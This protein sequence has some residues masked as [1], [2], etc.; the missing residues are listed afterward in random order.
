MRRRPIRLKYGNT[1]AVT[2]ASGLL[3]SSFVLAAASKWN[4]IGYYHGHV[5]KPPG[6]DCVPI[7][8]NNLETI[9]PALNASRPDLIIHLAA[10]TKPDWCEDHQRETERLNVLAT[11]RLA[12]WAAERKVR[13]VFL[14]TDS[15]FD[16]KKGEYVERDVPRPLNVYATTKLQAEMIVRSATADHLIVRANMY[17]WNAQEK[18]SLAEWILERLL[19]AQQV[20]GFVDV[21]FSPLLVNTLADVILELIERQASGTYHVASADSISKYDFASSLASLF[22]LDASLCVKVFSK[23]VPF[24]AQRPLNTSMRPLALERDYGIEA[25]TVMTD[26]ERFKELRD[27]GFA[28]NL[29]HYCRFSL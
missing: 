19:R 24:R 22:G 4:V 13:I 26:L 23:S 5:F 2:G 14:S 29:K 3:G 27:S 18:Q 1:M 17:G 10:Y 7:D 15:I 9:A 12:E 16:G 28:A 21:I 8:L 11:E 20:P 6:V 25:P